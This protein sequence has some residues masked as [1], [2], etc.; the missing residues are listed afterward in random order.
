LIPEVR[1]FLQRLRKAWPYA[2]FLCDLDNAF[3]SFDAFAHLRDFKVIELDRTEDLWI[4]I[5]MCQLGDYVRQS[6]ETIQA[7]GQRA[8][9]TNTEIQTRE[10]QLGQ[11]IELQCGPFRSPQTPPKHNE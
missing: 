6:R 3:I 2:P 4:D 10:T 1:D 11:Y 9:M 8:G 5:N 7:L